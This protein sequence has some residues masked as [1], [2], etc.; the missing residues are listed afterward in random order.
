MFAY[1]LI[2]LSFGQDFVV[3]AV[4]Q[5][6]DATLDTAHE[7]LDDHAAGGITKHTAQHLF[8]FLLGFVEGGEYEY[9]L[10]GAQSVGLQ[11]VGGF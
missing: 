7:L 2:I 4:S 11:H 8:Q 9:A 1:A 6:E 3:L 10:S 5:Y